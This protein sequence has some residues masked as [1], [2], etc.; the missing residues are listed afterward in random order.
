MELNGIKSGGLPLR[1]KF[2]IVF[3]PVEV[4]YVLLYQ[5]LDGYFSSI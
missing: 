4:V 2:W 1:Q 3:L 5:I